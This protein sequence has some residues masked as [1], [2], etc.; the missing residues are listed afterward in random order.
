MLV[1]A[2]ARSLRDPFV[3][4]RNAALQALAA[5]ADLFPEE[6]C[7]NKLLPALC[8]SLLDKEKYDNH[9]TPLSRTMLTSTRIVRDQ[10]NKTLDVYLTRV[11]KHGTTLPETV[12]PPPSAG[13]IN[14]AA[15]RIGTP[16]NDTSWAGWAVSSFTNKLAAASGD[17]EA[18]PSSNATRPSQEP[19]SSSVP[20]RPSTESTRPNTG[21]A[22]NLHR[23]ALNAH[24]GPVLLRT[25]TDQFF[26]VAQAEDDEIDAAW[27]EM[28]EDSFFDAPVTPAITSTAA[29]W[30]DGGEPDFAGWLS[31]QAQAKSKA[32]LPKGLSKAPPST[33]GRP[34]TARI[35][36]TG[37]IGS[38]AGTKKLSTTIT[39]PHI[40]KHQQ[41]D[42]K[43]KESAADD[44]W[45][46]AWD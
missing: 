45:G 18:K 23:K 16:Q 4:A 12:L 21:S 43:P 19:R 26:D 2:F 29:I 13:A 25:T 11:R 30:D 32:P 46:D 8:P 42:T 39:K 5:T 40:I 22:T 41:I 24:T 31:A 14:G 33:N 17:M 27:G 15:P 28:G 37:T 9:S 38:G 20:P 44:D 10:A 7:A 34:T 36:T 35:T 6:D 1:A 3:H